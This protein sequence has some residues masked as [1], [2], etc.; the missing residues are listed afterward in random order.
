MATGCHGN[1]EHLFINRIHKFLTLKI[2]IFTAKKK[3]PLSAIG[4]EHIDKYIKT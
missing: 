2:A 3:N 4:K 1:R